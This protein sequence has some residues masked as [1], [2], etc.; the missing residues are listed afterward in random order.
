M[1][2][3]IECLSGPE[4]NY[5]DKIGSGDASDNKGENQDSGR[6][7]DALREH[8]ELGIPSLPDD[9]EDDEGGA[10]QKW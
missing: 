5:A 8:G 6:L 4:G 10:K 3:D 7:V 1:A 9:E 2:V